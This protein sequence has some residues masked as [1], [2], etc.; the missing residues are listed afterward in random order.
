MHLICVKY[1]STLHMHDRRS[2][3]RPIIKYQKYV[4]LLLSAAEAYDN[5]M[6]NMKSC[7]R[8]HLLHTDIQYD[9]SSDEDEKEAFIVDTYLTM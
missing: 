3:G 4:P 6:K 7:G 1:E 9:E 5:S 8:H 2:E